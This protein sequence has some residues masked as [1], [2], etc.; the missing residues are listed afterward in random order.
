MALIYKPECKRDCTIKTILD[1]NLGSK[2]HLPLTF[3]CHIGEVKAL[4]IMVSHL[5]IICGGII[6]EYTA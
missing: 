5:S 3:L 4:L 1:V 2:L 6:I